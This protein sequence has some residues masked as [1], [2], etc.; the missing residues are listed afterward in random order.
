[1]TIGPFV[2]GLFGR[3]ERQISDAYRSI[4]LDLGALVDL[5]HEWRPDAER[6]LEIGCGEGQ[7]TERLRRRYPNAAITAID[8]SPRLGRLYRGAPHNVRFIQCTAR[9]IAETASRQHDLIVISDVLHHVP[10]E[11]RQGV[12]EAARTALAPDGTLV[13]KDWEIDGSLIHRLCH[14]SDRWLTGDHIS[15]MTRPE[16]QERLAASFGPA[17]LLREARVAPRW[18]NLA[19][20]V[21]PSTPRAGTG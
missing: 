14:A 9:Q 21:R 6:I 5:I 4:Y 16:M 2:R 18:N 3:Y 20:L 12:L 15:Y 10:V 7:V 17:A 1:M 8:I 13:F 11:L 19:F